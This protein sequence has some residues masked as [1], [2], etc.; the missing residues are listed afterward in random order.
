M[1]TAWRVAS[2]SI[3]QPA[4]P[5]RRR[6]TTRRAGNDGPVRSAQTR[7]P[8][9][10]KSQL[11]LIVFAALACQ[12]AQAEVY[13]WVDENGR[14]HF[15]D[16]APPQQKAKVVELKNVDVSDARRREAEQRAAREKGLV[17]SGAPASASGT[18]QE[19][20][21]NST[22]TVEKPRRPESRDR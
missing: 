11:A 22:K 15:S 20:D 3:H 4:L 17:Q 21:D 9:D 1:A 5:D 8:T 7:K 14:T 10:M 13:K 6:R 2:Y 12:A 16:T 18:P 19:S